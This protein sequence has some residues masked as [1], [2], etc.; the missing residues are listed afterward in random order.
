MNNTTFVEIIHQHN[1]TMNSLNKIILH[2]GNIVCIANNLWYACFCV[3]VGRDKFNLINI[4]NI[5][6]FYYY[7]HFKH[8]I[9]KYTCSIHLAIT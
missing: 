9:M 5:N 7:K 1:V 2:G 4:H 6:G 8:V 3:I